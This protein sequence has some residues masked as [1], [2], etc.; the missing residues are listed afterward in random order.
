MVR[1]FFGRCSMLISA[2]GLMVLLLWVLL[3]ASGPA[4]GAEPSAA[5]L[6]AAGGVNDLQSSIQRAPVGLR[7]ERVVGRAG[8]RTGWLD[9]AI[10]TELSP[11]SVGENPV[12][13]PAEQEET[14]SP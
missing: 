3:A 11:I 10:F 5:D 6:R 4:A 7:D 9:P 13:L 12:R 2:T 1:N 14:P 8:E